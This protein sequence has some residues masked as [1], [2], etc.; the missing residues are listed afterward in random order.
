MDNELD[1][2]VEQ[3][4]VKLKET[5]RANEYEALLRHFNEHD[6]LHKDELQKIF[7]LYLH[8]KKPKHP[9]CDKY[10]GRRISW[11]SR[12]KYL[13]CPKCG[14]DIRPIVIRWSDEIKA[15]Y[16]NKKEN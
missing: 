1:K 7:N 11:F 14:K 5:M 10:S 12:S 8:C 16:V 4:M 6:T 2:L 13:F 3:S 15:E 9:C